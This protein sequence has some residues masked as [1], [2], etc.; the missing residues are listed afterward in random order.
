MPRSPRK[1]ETLKI[2]KDRGI[3]VGTILDVGVLHGTG[4]LMGAWPAVKH[5]LFEPV[6]EFAEKI[7]SNYARIPHELHTVAV[8]DSDGEVTLKTQALIQGMEISHSK[9]VDG[10]AGSEP[11]TRRVP[12]VRL[13][14]FLKGRSLPEPFLLKVDVDGAELQ[15]LRGAAETLKRCSVVIVE[16]V[17]PELVQRIQAVQAA[18]FQLFDLSEPAYYDKV[19]WQC[20]A[21]LIRKDLHQKHFK[22]LT[23]KVE[24]GMYEVFR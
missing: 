3:P 9:M 2:I 6:A 23:G 24:P 16:C 22:Q 7:R 17:G 15:V 18:G 1:D 12:K 20:D 4:E 13:D 11:G 19:F 21:V 14:T 5:V 8:G 10:Q